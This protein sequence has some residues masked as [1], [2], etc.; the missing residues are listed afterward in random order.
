MKISNLL[1]SISLFLFVSLSVQAQNIDTKLDK[2]QTD[3]MNSNFEVALGEC[4]SL[5]TAGGG[6]SLQQATLYSYSGIASEQLKKAP[7]AIK[8]YKKAVQL[9]VPRLDIYDRLISLTKKSGDDDDYEF[10]LNEKMKAFPDF[11]K[12]I[13]QSLAHLYLQTK[14]YDKLIET[15]KELTVWFPNNPTFFSYQGAA[16]QNLGQV[17]KAT[18]DYKKVLELDPENAY[19]NMAYGMI[20]YRKASKIFD[21]S[22]KEYEAIKKPDWK[23]FNKYDK[24]LAGPKSIYQ[25]ALPYLLKAYSDKNYSSSLKGVLSRIYTRLGEKDKAAQYK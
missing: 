14:Q 10:A 17:D 15:T 16:Y 4:E 19:A 12:S 18:A 2:I 21:K 24:S 9:K 25:E 1:L 6:D 11:R 23:D 7:D 8:Y 5:I 20:L 3:L 13:V 22:K